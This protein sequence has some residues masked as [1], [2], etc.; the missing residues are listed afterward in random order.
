M[1]LLFV[2][3]LRMIRHNYKVNIACVF[4]IMIGIT[5]YTGMSNMSVNL[6]NSV[7]MYY[8]E[9]RLADVF[10]DL[11]GMP[12]SRLSVLESIPG[13]EEIHAY[14]SLDVRA[15][16]PG[17]RNVTTLRLNGI[18][19]G[20]QG[21]LNGY[22]FDGVPLTD[23]NEIH[24]GLGF[25]DAHNIKMFDRV[26]VILNGQRHSLV[27]NGTAMSPEYVYVIPDAGMLYPDKAAFDIAYLDVADLERM[28]GQEGIVNRV[29]FQLEPGIKFEDV[30]GALS[31]RLKNYGL[32]RLYPQKDQLS[33]Q[34][35][36]QE[37][38][39]IH[40]M[41]TSVPSL[42]LLIAVVIL[43]IMLRRMVEQ[44]RTIL[45]TLKA[46]GFSGGQILI[47][48]LQ[49]GAFIGM[50]G[51]IPGAILGVFLS[52]YLFEMYQEFFN[53]PDMQPVI[54]A[55]YY[56]LG[57]LI[58]VITGT[59]A[60]FLG[61]K[62]LLR[63]KPAESMRAQAPLSVQET[64]VDRLRIFRLFLTS[65]GM[66]SLR[67]IFRNKL[68]STFIILS[69][70]LSFSLMAAIFSFNLMVEQMLYDQFTKAQVYE[71]K[72]VFKT[73]VPVGGAISALRNID[74]VKSVEGIFEVPILLKKDHRSAGCVLTGIRED[75]TLFYVVNSDNRRYRP[76]SGGMLITKNLADK[77]GIEKDDLVLLESA[78]GQEDIQIRISDIVEQNFGSG[79]Y[80]DIEAM[81]KLFR[82]DALASSLIFDPVDK[83]AGERIGEVLLTAANI[84]SIENAA[85]ALATYRDMMDSYSFIFLIMAVMS[86]FIGFAVIYNISKVSLSERSRELATM[87]V[88]G[89]TVRETAEVMATEHWF[90][91]V[92]GLVLGIPMT[93]AIRH[94]LSANIASDLF[95]IPTETPLNAFL[96][97]AAGCILT[98]VMANRAATASI[99]KFD[100]VEVLKERE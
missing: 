37:I 59:A 81:A 83:Q 10:A 98:V 1:R 7:Q 99:R 33:Y 50:A 36:D 85:N 27:V 75:S 15:I 70:M 6:K 22:T 63:L 38:T 46:F 100:M 96:L 94:G 60:A 45:G 16:I 95:V 54:M 39:Q 12:K 80:M 53:V 49:Y 57:I 61:A 5:M 73:P 68:R 97:A 19:P 64:I 84:S 55:E 41:S 2:K 71:M 11:T 21:G 34:I 67:Y 26:D 58:A 93:F 42:F 23:S 91:L 65:R 44:E 78:Y 29:S 28:S 92:W 82:T 88:L 77:L 35:M 9:Y 48:Y 86:V 4:V 17:Y 32:T 31:D 40:A 74:G 43:Y 87:R 13:I 3:M 20:E 51:G 62:G 30:R 72:A 90:L 56:L 8:R 24:L 79:C 52:D 18:D 47:H 66:M 76:P 25:T 69:I 14:Y 89:I